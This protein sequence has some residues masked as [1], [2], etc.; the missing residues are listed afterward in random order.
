MV[1]LTKIFSE[2]LQGFIKI[3][4]LL[5]LN[6]Y[7]TEKKSYKNSVHQESKNI[8]SKVSQQVNIQNFDEVPEFHL[9][10]YGSGAKR[11]IE[12]HAEKQDSKTLVLESIEI[13]L[14]KTKIE[15]QFTRLL[16]LTDINFTDSLFTTEEP[17]I[18]VRVNYRTLDGKKYQLL[19]AMAQEKRADGLFNVLLS[20]SPYIRNINSN[21]D[22]SELEKGVLEKLYRDYKETRTRTK[23]KATDAYKELDIKDGQDISTLHDS[24]FIQI[25]VDGTHECFLITTEGIR[26]MDNQP[27]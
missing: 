9:H 27:V 8:F 5:T 3:K 4:S 25:I 14:T 19:Q 22:I 11:K 26:Y 2:L 18:N 6:F 17:E 20:G 7:K 21:G 24:K 1:E 16:P 23:W 15:R 13:G 12:G 10:L